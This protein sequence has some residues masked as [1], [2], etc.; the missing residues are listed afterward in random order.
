MRVGAREQVARCVSCDGA[1]STGRIRDLRLNHQLEH[2]KGRGFP[3]GALAERFPPPASLQTKQPN[4]APFD[5]SQ[6][7]LQMMAKADNWMVLYHIPVLHSP[8]DANQAL[9]TQ[10]WP[11]DGERWL[12]APR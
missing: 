11:G 7:L 10:A 1:G 5:V 8:Y 3:L 9:F 6:A 2:E 12:T 4:A